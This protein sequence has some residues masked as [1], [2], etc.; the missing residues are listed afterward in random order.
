MNLI[1]KATFISLTIISTLSCKRDKFCNTNLSE[2]DQ[3]KY[4]KLS[5]LYLSDIN[6]KS[7]LT[8]DEI[9]IN[10]V[11]KK[12]IDEIKLKPIEISKYKNTF[13]A[14]L[15]ENET[16]YMER[17]ELYL[18]VSNDTLQTSLRWNTEGDQQFILN[19]QHKLNK[20]MRLRSISIHN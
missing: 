10:P 11:Y 17:D 14:E 1:I 12:I 3:T 20:N 9:E 4:L 19:C 15:K 8:W 5:Q 6:Q 18:T 7:K 2:S 13:T 16:W